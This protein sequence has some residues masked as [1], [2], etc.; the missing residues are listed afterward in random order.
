MSDEVVSVDG[1]WRIAV[2]MDSPEDRFAVQ[3][4]Q[5][6][7][8]EDTVLRTLPIEA[9]PAT[10]SFSERRILVGNPQE[11]PVLVQLL[12]SSEID[13]DEVLE[14]DKHGQGYVLVITPSNIVVAAK[15]SAGRFY[16]AVSLSWLIQASDGQLRFPHVTI[17]DWPDF[18]IRG[19]YGVGQ[20]S[21]GGELIDTTSDAEKWIDCL[22]RYKYNMWT[23]ALVA[24]SGDP[25]TMVQRRQYLSARHFRST[26]RLAPWSLRH[27]YDQLYEGV[28]AQ[29]VG[30]MFDDDDLAV[31]ADEGLSASADFETGLPSGWH[32]EHQIDG[33]DYWAVIHDDHHSGSTSV[34]LRL[35]EDHSEVAN[36]SSSFLYSPRYQLIPNRLYLLSFW[37]KVY[38]Q[39]GTR[40][41]QVS[42]TPCDKD[43]QKLYHRSRLI[44]DSNWAKYCIPFSTYNDEDDM[45]VFSRAQGTG[46]L[47]LWLDDFELVEL[48]DKLVNI[49]DTGG[50]WVDVWNADRTVMYAEGV[51]YIFR[52][53]GAYDYENPLA[54]LRTTIERLPSGLI[55][56]RAEVK[57]DFDFVVNFQQRNPEYISLSDPSVVQLYGDYIDKAMTYLEPDYVFIA[58]C[59]VRG[60]NRDSRA[61]MEGLS[62]ADV[63]SQFL[64]QILHTI[65]SYN[66]TTRILIWDDMLNP[67]HNGGEDDYQVPYGGNYGKSWYALNRLEKKGVVLISWWY[68]EGYGAKMKLSPQLYS[69]KGF[70]FVGGTWANSENIRW[71]S[72]L[73]EQYGAL[74]LI[75]HEFSNNIEGVPVTA[76]YAWNAVRSYAEPH[77]P[78]GSDDPHRIDS[79]GDGVSDYEELTLY[80]TDLSQDGVSDN[81]LLRKVE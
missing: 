41:P 66:P 80:N 28:F 1:G 57:V 32:F 16:G 4:L 74:G 43:D 49:I 60:Y 25:S 17:T 48:N 35:A 23:D 22:A 2:D 67:Y 52:K 24:I 26:V 42:V 40:Y 5:T 10:R 76:Q 31:P 64:N 19:F 45:F 58:M 70:D 69:I 14:E 46:P 12:V 39:G 78:D 20:Y 27:S 36:G 18:E 44:T 30:M 79:D 9:I 47:E 8:K 53:T 72:Y 71:W 59:E 81:G 55:P 56:R 75:D 29:D 38:L 37:G 65:H 21:W 34:R 15:T 61:R 7:V 6:A 68:H 11:H 62:N 63:F 33:S 50:T 54:G 77:N 3:Y 73:C 13:F 51:D